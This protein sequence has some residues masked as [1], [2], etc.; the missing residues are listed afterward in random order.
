MAG[1][2]E[3]FGH[4]AADNEENF[5]KIVVVG[6]G[7]FGRKHLDGLKNIDGVE[8]VSLAGGS[9]ESTEK[10]A[11]QYGI[12]HWTTNL[13]EALAQPGV[14]AAIITSPTQIHAKQAIQTMRAGK[15]VEIEIPIADTLADAEAID[16]VQRET[17]RIAM[18]GHTRRFNPSHQW[19]HNRIKAGEL[20][21]QHLVVQTFFFRRQNINLEGKPRSWTDH[22]LWHH[23]CHTVDLFHYQT[24]EAPTNVHALEGPKHPELGIAMDMSIG[25]KT[26]S[27][28]VCTLALSFN[29]EGPQGTFFRYICDNGTYIARYDDLFDGNDKQIDLSGVAVSMNGIELQDREFVAAIREKREP[30]SSVAQVLPA[31]RTLDRLEK[32]LTGAAK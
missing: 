26:P 2:G 31:M 17:G 23:A 6:Q 11:K 8:V 32:S 1:A 3:Y 19:V 21:L 9:A 20:K 16:K 12:R 7:A 28:A 24:G 18:A 25:M 5:M 14:E 4:I 22:L 15:H 13:D 27:G 29:N 30:N 10:V